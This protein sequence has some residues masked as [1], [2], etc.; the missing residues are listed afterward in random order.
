MPVEG[1]IDHP[2]T[3][4]AS[5]SVFG[6]ITRILLHRWLTYPIAGP[7]ADTELRA[8]SRLN[9]KTW[10]EAKPSITQAVTDLWPSMEANARQ[11]LG[12]ERGLE[13]AR[14]RAAISLK[15]RTDAAAPLNRLSAHNSP[16]EAQINLAMPSVRERPHPQHEATKLQ[17]TLIDGPRKIEGNLSFSTLE[18]ITASSPALKR[19]G[20]KDTPPA[21]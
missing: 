10:L 17:H 5:S 15:K 9:A 7:T 14:M 19:Q 13:N 12:G 2:L 4:S 18:V 20:M 6:A 1:L 11:R 21:R 8:I 16:R 3:I